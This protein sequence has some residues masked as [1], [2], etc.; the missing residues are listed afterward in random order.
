MNNNNILIYFKETGEISRVVNEENGQECS[1]D[2][3]M[4]VEE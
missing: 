3:V 1:F 2:C 4:E